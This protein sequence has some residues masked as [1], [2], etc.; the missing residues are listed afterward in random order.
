MSWK[1]N[2]PLI[3]ILRGIT[4]DEVE[5]HVEVLVDAGFDA[6]EIPLN[7]PDWAISIPKAIKRYGDRVMI[8]AGTVLTVEQ[9][10]QLA[11]LGCQLIVTPN[12]N[13][14]VIQ[15]A[16]KF[17]MTICPGC[18][19]PTEVFTAIRAG[20]NNI[21][22]FPSSL[23]GPD[24]IKALKT[25]L[26]KEISV[27]AVGGVTPENLKE[28]LDA[29]YVG[30]GLGTYLYKAGQSVTRTQKQ[31]QAFVAAYKRAAQDQ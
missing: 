5:Q 31:A 6:I 22:I 3:A 11:D 18:A 14:D 26:P 20:S 23:F 21:K 12:I 7:S 2:L 9:V 25:V 27:F 4:P 17:G 30:A 1:T 28:Y 15:R 19:T 29:G 16:V 13:E 8:G 10:D 24:Y